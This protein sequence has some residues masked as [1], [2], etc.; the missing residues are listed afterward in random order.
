MRCDWLSHALVA[1]VSTEDVR[2][3]PWRP[4]AIFYKPYIPSEIAT[5]GSQGFW[6]KHLRM[7]LIPRILSVTSLAS[8]PYLNLYKNCGHL[9]T[10]GF[11]RGKIF[12][13]VH[14]N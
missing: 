10:R 6:T 9:C 14:L 1:K 5:T 4:Q 3:D 13:E 12:I 8:L 7:S 2:A 11:H